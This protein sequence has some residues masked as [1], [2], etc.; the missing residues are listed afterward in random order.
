[1]PIRGENIGTAYV[2]IL[3]DGSDL[4]DSI[5]DAFK[6][7][8]DVFEQQGNR[9]S[10]M[11]KKA[12]ADEL[13]SHT[14][15]TTLQNA[16]AKSLA[17]SDALDRYIRSPVWTRFRAGLTR[18]FGEAGTVAGKRLEESLIEGMSFDRLEARVDNM[19]KEISDAVR[20]IQRLETAQAKE[21]ERVHKESV[22]NVKAEYDDL[23][24]SVERFSTGLSIDRSRKNLIDDLRRIRTEM[25]RLGLV[26]H[27]L[28][29]DFNDYHRRIRLAHP[30]LARFS[31][32]ID[33][34]AFG[35]GKAF[36]RGSRNDFLNFMG[37]VASGM[38]RLINIVPRGA[39]ALSD[40]VGRARLAGER[41]G[42]IAALGSVV[43]DLGKVV[44][45][46]GAVFAGA[47]VFAGPLLAILSQLAG[48]I[49]ALASSIGFALV[50]AL[51]ALPAVALPAA[52]GIATVALAF[53][54]LSE[55]EEKALKH[56]VRP[57]IDAFERLS[58]VAR[59]GLFDNVAS[60][61]ERFADVIDGTRVIMRDLGEAVSAVVDG[62]L[63]MMETP[64]FAAF[65][66][67][68]GV[69]LPD[70]IEAL[71]RITGEVVG[72]L[73]GLFVGMIPF[74][75][76][77][78]SYLEDI[79]SE[80]NDWANSTEGQSDIGAFFERT[81]D[82]LSAV[83]GFLGSV[84]DLLFELL[85]AGQGAGD[86]LFGSMTENIDQWTQ[87][88]RDN[89]DILDDWFQSAEAFGRALGL[90]LEG[91]GDVF[92]ALDNEFSRA[93][94]STV[95]DIFAGALEGIATVLELV[96]NLFGVGEGAALGFAG[97]VAAAALVL[98]RLTG[99]FTGLQ[100]G[101]TNFIGTGG[102]AIGRMA[103]LS[104]AART[105]AGVGGLLALTAG[106]Q[107]SN[108]ELGV[109]LQTLGGAAT[110]F[111]IAGPIGALIGGAGAG[112][113][114]LATAGK[115]AADA[116]ADV[117]T[118]W[119]GVAGTLDEVTGATTAATEAFIYDTLARK[120][121]LGQLEQEGIS[122]RLVVD[123][124]LGD[125]DARQR[126]NEVMAGEQSELDGLNA[127][128]A[129][130]TD[131]RRDLALQEAEGGG[132][133]G[134]Q[135]DRLAAYDDEIEKTEEAITAQ[136]NLIDTID[137]GKD[138]I[139]A[140]TRRMQDRAQALQDFSSLAGKI[141]K[142]IISK[143]EATG[144]KPTTDGIARIA[145]QYDLMDKRE[146]QSLIEA[147]GVETTVKEVKGVI[148]ILE[149]LGRQ[150]PKPELDADGRPIRQ[151]VN[152]AAGLL[153]G[154]GRIV[155]TPKVNVDNSGARAGISETERWLNSIQDETVYVNVE[156]RS[157]G[158]QEYTAT[159]G[160]FTYEQSRIIAEAGPEAVVPLNRPLNQVDPSV[161]FLSAIAQGIAVPMGSGKRIDV[162][163]ITVIAPQAD[164][165]A[166][167]VHTVNELAS[168]GYF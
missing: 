98:P 46:L 36:G 55:A 115:D 137:S 146:I 54:N 53:V 82:S 159:G 153:A 113:I 121:I 143:I 66:Q 19:S 97:Q 111:A 140:D 11:Y 6:D 14:T 96:A 4:S 112:L 165:R 93:L 141:P 31:R 59:E 24:N 95:F 23:I 20:E 10:K 7:T 71:G 138:E 105:A 75:R 154:L 134:A 61:A 13:S 18:Q 132:L 37:V 158:V 155:V 63:T 161:R 34:A 101:L 87:A 64:A 164:P 62:W 142:R 99:A 104:A 74:M 72:G 148:A 8:D 168:T 42:P 41:G 89:P 79:T 90:V 70:A 133:T 69:F 35:F 5:K 107:S 91:L 124:M 65:N 16:L 49:T 114:G 60:Q 84:R 117:K 52:A 43:L 81:A 21:T 45:S 108:T 106:A 57:V 147:T 103:A 162:G 128:L 102:T 73:G 88:I 163:G 78:L 51:G 152:T 83:A 125:I 145:R 80:F 40:F 166:V 15:Q 86:S 129:D 139:A 3:A 144:I 136:K 56:D 17:R 44:G 100:T 25:G 123:A 29:L 131:K 149:D 160:V 2:R 68:M 156:R 22:R 28:N 30:D 120:G 26:T 39:A 135:R 126:L 48:V 94:T 122:R 110:G 116:A 47:F 151:E 127:K 27:E 92:S 167:A 32:L 67:M 85:D 76:D 50:G 33:T 1:M 109:L 9:H 130:L 38:V 12:F 77:V 119:D 157:G 58:D 118:Q 150:K